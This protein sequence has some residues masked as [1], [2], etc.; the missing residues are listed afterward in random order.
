ML[1]EF[2]RI[3]CILSSVVAFSN[4]L[5]AETEGLGADILIQSSKAGVQN[6]ISFWEM[7]ERGGW[8]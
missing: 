4:S 7:G 1:K 6:K 8:Q 3:L 5:L 2:I